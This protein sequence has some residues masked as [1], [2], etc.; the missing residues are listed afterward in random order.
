MLKGVRFRPAAE[1]DFEALHDL[2]ARTMRPH[3]ER[4]GRWDPERRRR[5]A[6]AAFD[7]GGIRVIE[8]DGATIG[9]IGFRRH[10]DHAEISAFFLEPSCQ[11]QGL[12]SAILALLVAEAEGLPVHLEVLKQSPA[13]RFYERAGFVRGAE[14]DYDWLYILPAAPPESNS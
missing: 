11:G 6:R 1:A 3:L 9:C 13:M 5:N 10:A 2:S 12:G 14:Q 8:R 7:A 4:I